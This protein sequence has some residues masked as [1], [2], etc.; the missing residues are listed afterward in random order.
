MTM[1]APS[2][3]G[4]PRTAG[5][6]R[7][8]AMRL[9]A[10]EYQR[11]FDLPHA[12]GP[13]DRAKPTECPGWDVR[14]MAAHALGMVEMAASIRESNR[15]LKLA[16]RRGG[17]FIDALTALQVNERAHMTPA[18]I[19]ARFAARA[20]K[21]ARARRRAP[22]FARRRTI[23]IPQQVG[24]REEAWTTG[25]LLDVILTRDPWMHRVDIVRATGA[26]RP[27]RRPVRPAG[28]YPARP[29]GQHVLRHRDHVHRAPAAAGP[30]H[31]LNPG[32]SLDVGDRWLTGFRPPL[33]DN[34]ATVGVLDTH[35]GVC[36]SSDCFGAPLPTAEQ[37]TAEDAAAANRGEL[38]AEQLLWATVDSP[39]V[40]TVD[41]VK[42]AASFASLRDFGRLPSS[43]PTCRRS[44]PT[45]PTLIATLLGAPQATPFT[46]P[47]QAALEAML[48]QFQPA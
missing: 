15:Q 11:F 48:G 41:P 14:A 5:L 42:F 27:H 36:L 1:T 8:A 18:Q 3:P 2:E 6:P 47:D 7:E 44:S 26:P 35:V 17:V 19:T 22:G 29:R 16:R 46:G 21:A 12:L 24:G 33:F 20:P 30:G 39:W 23:P 31:L 13:D 40:H 43:A 38:R 25:Y 10:T 32:Q 45:A 37:A 28:G 9:A 4:K 34:P